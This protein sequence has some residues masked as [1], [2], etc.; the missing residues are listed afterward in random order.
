MKLLHPV[1]PFVTEEIWGNLRATF[2]YPAR[3][4]AES[5]LESSF[6]GESAGRIDA[7]IDAQ[8]GMLQE[9]IVALRT[10]RSENNV[11]PDKK[12]EAIVIPERAEHA[13]WLRE[14]KALIEMF[15]K[16]SSL[17]IDTAATKP[18]FA[19]QGVVRG[20]QVF[21]QLEG[22]ID[23]AVEMDRL[24]RELERLNKLVQSTAARLESPSFAGKAPADVVAREKEKYQGLLA[25][26]DKVEHSLAALKG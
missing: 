20:C 2:R 14:Q 17:T 8:F 11:P 12:G 26:R 9:V 3:L 18:A 13:E 21:L 15:G 7:A 19:G 23:R 1:M 16:L 22:L 10:I 5:V 24:G 4:D 6:P 25:N